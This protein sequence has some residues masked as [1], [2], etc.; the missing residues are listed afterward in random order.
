MA[1]RSPG[2][3]DRHDRGVVVAIAGSARAETAKGIV[4]RSISLASPVVDLIEDDNQIDG[5]FLVSLVPHSGA[6][7]RD[8]RMLRRSSNRGMNPELRRR[9][10]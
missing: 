2:A 5:R 6:E 1:K 8:L 7:Q 3:G 10:A 9:F 4:D